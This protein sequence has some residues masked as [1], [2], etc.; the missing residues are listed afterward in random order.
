[1]Q[2]LGGFVGGEVGKTWGK[3]LRKGRQNRAKA[4][5]NRAKAAQKK[6][7][8]QRRLKIAQ[9]RLKLR[10]AGNKGNKVVGVGEGGHGRARAGRVWRHW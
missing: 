7:I 6:T 5:Q 9:R 2:V 10:K 4:A 8:A 1:M 3:K